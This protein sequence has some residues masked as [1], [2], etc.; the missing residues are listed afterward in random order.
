[1]PKASKNL[2]KFNK[3]H[4]SIKIL[5]IIYA[6][7]KCLPEKIFSCDDNLSKLFTSKT[8]KHIAH[9][10]EKVLCRPKKLCYINNQ[11]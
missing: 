5:F 4:K 8:N 9:Y 11:L 2:L 7:T 3:N 10:F 6:D 1:M